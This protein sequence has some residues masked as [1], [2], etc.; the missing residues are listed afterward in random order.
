MPFSIPR[1][2]RVVLAVLLLA[3]CGG[4]RELVL[5]L[6]ESAVVDHNTPTGKSK[7]RITPTVV[8]RGSTSDLTQT[9]LKP[10]QYLGITPLYV[11]VTVEN[12]GRSDLVNSFP[13]FYLQGV[14]DRGE[15]MP[16]FQIIGFDRCPSE[17]REPFRPGERYQTCV[18]LLPPVGHEA[19]G[20]LYDPH[21]V[22]Q[23]GSG[24]VTWKLN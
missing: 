7:L 22:T 15:T 5:G 17:D 20:L 4:G 2:A 8:E 16:A 18:V 10:G 24:E 6:G 14:D 11:R 21:P 12:P 3:G 13:E 9:T 1:T 19:V 23:S